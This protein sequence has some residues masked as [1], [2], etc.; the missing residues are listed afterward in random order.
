MLKEV[1]DDNTLSNAHVFEWHKRFSE[2]CEEV[3]VDERLGLFV[4]ARNVNQSIKTKIMN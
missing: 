3:E 2:L 4:T 1:L